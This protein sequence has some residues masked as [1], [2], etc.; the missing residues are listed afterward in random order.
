MISLDA[1]YA[2]WITPDLPLYGNDHERG[3]FAP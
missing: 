2:Q 1:A 3:D